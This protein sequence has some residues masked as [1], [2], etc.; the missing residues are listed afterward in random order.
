MSHVICFHGNFGKTYMKHFLVDLTMRNLKSAS[1]LAIGTQLA[2][3]R[4][5]HL[6]RLIDSV[7]LMHFSHSPY[8]LHENHL[9]LTQ[10]YLKIKIKYFLSTTIHI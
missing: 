6:I 2:I 7:V 10:E 1:L 9:N 5:P 4:I 3:A 8:V